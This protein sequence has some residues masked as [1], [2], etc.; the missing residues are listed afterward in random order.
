MN[1]KNDENERNLLLKERVYELLNK[2][3]IPIS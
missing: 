3:I 1:N 2:F